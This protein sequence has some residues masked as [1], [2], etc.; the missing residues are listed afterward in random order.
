MVGHQPWLVTTYNSCWLYA[1]FASFIGMDG[2][3]TAS[4]KKS[5]DFFCIHKWMWWQ[6]MYPL[7]VLEIRIKDIKD[8]GLVRNLDISLFIDRCILLLLAQP[9][10]FRN[11]LT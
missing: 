10:Q 11:T 7:A 3:L 4:I 8:I 5:R 6:V 2:T 9:R 1:P